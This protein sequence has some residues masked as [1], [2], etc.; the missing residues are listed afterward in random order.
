M[1]PLWPNSNSVHP[2]GANQF[3]D[4]VDEGLEKE[5]VLE[6]EPHVAVPNGRVVIRLE[7]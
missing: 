6:V 1:H 2:T 4:Q 7:K 5:E 3:K